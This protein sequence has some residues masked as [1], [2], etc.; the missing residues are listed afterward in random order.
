MFLKIVDWSILMI[1]KRREYRRHQNKRIIKKRK[2]MAKAWG[3]NYRDGVLRKHNMTC[4]CGMCNVN[5]PHNLPKAVLGF[6]DIER[7]KV[8]EERIIEV[9]NERV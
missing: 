4:S 9:I 2:K 7:L 1:H 3:L 8:M 6:K 5:H